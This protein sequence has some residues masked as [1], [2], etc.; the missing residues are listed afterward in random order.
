MKVPKPKKEKTLDQL[1]K[2]FVIQGMRRASYRW[3][4]RNKC[5]TAARV[6]R[7]IYLCNHCKL[8]YKKQEIK[9]DHIFPVVDPIVGFDGFD[10]YAKRLFCLAEEMQCLCK[11]CHSAK[12]L[13]ENFLRKQARDK[14]K[15]Q[16][17]A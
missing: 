1:R 6:S 4:E 12:T 17:K 9:I 2:E 10:T 3:P 14:K 15:E 16:E 7:G 8:Q 5:L 13:T 11:S